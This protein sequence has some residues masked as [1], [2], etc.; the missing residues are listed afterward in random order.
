[1]FYT[2]QAIPLPLL[3]SGDLG[4][5]T[6]LLSSRRLPD[7]EQSLHCLMYSFYLRLALIFQVLIQLP[8]EK[9]VIKTSCPHFQKPFV[10]QGFKNRKKM[11]VTFYT[12]CGIIFSLLYSMCQIW[13][14]W[15]FIL[16]KVKGRFSA[17][18]FF[19]LPSIW[20]IDSSHTTN[21][22]PH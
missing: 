10:I 21:S 22:F 20:L 9:P 13:F 7:P 17:C 1:M 15:Q 2:Q 18:S 4:P 11:Q 14:L 5:E 16:Y 12:E 6:Q 3:P 8:G 19:S